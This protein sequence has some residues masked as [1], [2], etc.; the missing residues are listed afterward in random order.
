MSVNALLS[1]KDLLERLK[2]TKVIARASSKISLEGFSKNPGTERRLTATQAKSSFRDLVTIYDK[3]VEDFLLEELQK[4]F[5]NDLYVGE[6]SSY[7]KGSQE[8]LGDGLLWVIDPIDGTTNFSRSFPYFCTTLCLMHKQQKTNTLLLAVTY[9]PVRDEMFSAANSQGAFLN[10]EKISVSS[11]Q[12]LQHSLLVTGFSSQVSTKN[13]AP[14]KRFQNLTQ[15]T[16]GVRRLGSA[17]MD[18]AYV[19]VG[20]LDAYWE[21]ELN[22]WDVAAGALLVR[23]AGGLVSHFARDDEW[24]PWSG[25]ILASNGHIHNEIKDL[26]IQH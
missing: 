26:V 25:E 21:Y 6:E 11:V 3:K 19:A 24:T 13:E 17:A 23:E 20:R 2:I 16:L 5:P 4:V 10:D 9:D 15:K 7:G 14:F 22:A 12:D 18:L 1:S 8:N